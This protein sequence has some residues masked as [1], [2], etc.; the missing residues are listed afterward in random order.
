[1]KAFGNCFLSLIKR[2][3]G[4]PAMVMGYCSVII[5]FCF[6]QQSS[7]INRQLKEIIFQIAVLLLAIVVQENTRLELGDGTAGGAGDD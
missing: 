1:M 6:E 2:E 4:S 5:F 3:T 7:A